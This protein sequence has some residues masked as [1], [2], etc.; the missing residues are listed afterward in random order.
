MLDAAGARAIGIDPVHDMVVE[1]NRLGGTF[2]A[3]DGQKLP[4][5]SEAFDVTVSYL[6]LIDIPD[7][8]AAID[9]MVRV[10]RPRGLIVASIV[11]PMASSIPY[12]HKDERG[13]KLFWRVDKYF[14]E[15]PERVAWAGIEV[16]NWHR[17]LESY[18]NAFISHGLILDS[19]WE[20]RPTP[21]QAQERPSLE[22]QLRVPNFLLFRWRKP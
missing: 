2:V 13:N 15:R 14:E 4:F 10:T 5:A 1:A 16:S 12:W 3:G 9:E 11:H 18:M 20:P 7:F 6:A 8:A 17:P 21:A 19:F 22:D